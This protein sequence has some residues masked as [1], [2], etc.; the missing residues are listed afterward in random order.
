MG[1]ACDFY[2]AF[3]R[4]GE[5]PWEIEDRI[6]SESEQPKPKPKAKRLNDKNSIMIEITDEERDDVKKVQH[7]H[8]INP[9]HPSDLMYVELSLSLKHLYNEAVKSIQSVTGKKSISKASIIEWIDHYEGGYEWWLQNRDIRVD[10]ELNLILETA[11]KD[12]IETTSLRDLVLPEELESY[13]EPSIS[14]LEYIDRS[15]EDVLVSLRKRSTGLRDLADSIDTI[16]DDTNDYISSA[17]D[18]K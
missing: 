9:Y 2:E 16:I 6:M 7:Q 17:E 1:D 13:S 12:I 4:P 15:P 14:Y 10:D 18:E 11:E 8:K 5:Q 3:G